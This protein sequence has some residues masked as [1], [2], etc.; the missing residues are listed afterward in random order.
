MEG[1]LPKDRVV[2][3]GRGVASN[4]D[5]RFHS[6]QYEWDEGEEQLHS[7][8]LFLRDESKT[9][10]SRNESPDVGFSVG[11]NPYRGC[12]HGCIYCY[13]RPYHE[14][15][16]FSAGLDF[17]TKILV[18]ENAPGL[19]RK[20]LASRN[21]EPETILLSGATDCYQPIERKLQLTRRCLE[22]LVEF[23]NPVAVITKNALV[24]RD[25]DLLTSLAQVNAAYVGISLTTLEDDLCGKMEP[26]T[27]RPQ[28]RLEAIRKLAEAGIPVGVNI[29]PVIPGLTDEEIP[30]ILRSA[31]EAGARTAWM[32]PVR[33]PHGVK[34]LFS[35]WLT[36]HYPL[37]KEKILQRI[38]EVR[39]GALND[40]RFGS[41]MQGEGK[42][43]EQ[44]ALLFKVMKKRVGY[45]VDRIPLSTA[46]F[47]RIAQPGE[48][49]EFSIF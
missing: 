49:S 47:V 15:L 2:I 8:T 31:Y 48:Q 42:Y 28:A 18:K 38:M 41:R 36:T 32:A 30:R 11:L 19:L 7:K 4:P 10:L 40:S 1:D 12:E 33:L 27:S 21:W 13:A 44:I 25:L 6:I 14:Y 46:S 34:D 17:E 20:A 24:T 26:R 45:P 22:V 35:E 9:I 39:G 37:A 3:K 16:G 23:R 5:N 29:A 43:A